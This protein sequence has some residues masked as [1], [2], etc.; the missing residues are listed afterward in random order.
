MALFDTDIP[1]A[2]DYALI[3]AP[4]RVDDEL[5]DTDLTVS[6]ALSKIPSGDRENYRALYRWFEENSG[7][8]GSR[9]LGQR[10]P[11]VGFPHSAQRG[12]HTPSKRKY[13]AT[14]TLTKNSSYVDGAFA[15]LGDGTWVLHYCEHRNNANGAKVSTWNQPL[16]NCLIDGV[17]VG[18]F[19][20]EGN[21]SQSYLRALAFVEEYDPDS[22]VF[23]LHGPVSPETE[24]IF[25]AHESSQ[26][27]TEQDELPSVDEI[28][29]DTRQTILR[30]NIVR[31]GQRRFRSDLLQAYDGQCA[32]TGYDVNPVLQA[33]HIL[34]Y[35]GTPSN[36]VKNGIVLRADIHILFDRALLGIDPSDFKVVLSKSIADSRYEDINGKSIQLPKDKNL[37]PSED[38]VAASFARFRQIQSSL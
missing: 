17:P 13:A 20:Q 8:V 14:V 2:I 4:V 37:W 25:K 1:T 6:R 35:R 29:K 30:T 12:I 15:D 9:F 19:M 34:E 31:K 27:P 24:H 10:L 18:V 26:A 28:R 32:I 11:G 22:G 23:I 21:S 33:A 16:I 36:N 38:Y 7:T 5:P 3:S